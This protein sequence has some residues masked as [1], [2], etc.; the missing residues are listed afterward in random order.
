MGRG[1]VSA[2]LFLAMW[3]L[4]WSLLA[5][6]VIIPHFNT[7]H[8]YI[9]WDLGCVVGSGSGS[10]SATGLA[11]QTFHAWP[12]KLET[13]VMLVLPTAFIALGSPVALTVLP[14]L[15][16]RFLATNA[17]TGRRAGITTPPRCPSCSSGQ[18]R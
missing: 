12:T 3:G 6:T 13:V 8:Q 16:L 14:S 2:G 18:P 15:G 5:I 11:A 9:Y 10:F 4:G 17:F 7:N 1:S